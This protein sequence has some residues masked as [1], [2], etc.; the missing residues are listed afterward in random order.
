MSRI[1]TRD[2]G[3]GSWVSQDKLMGPRPNH[4]PHHLIPT[5]TNRYNMLR[6]CTVTHQSIRDTQINS[7]PSIAQ[8]HLSHKN[9]LASLTNPILPPVTS[10]PLAESASV[11]PGYHPLP[12]TKHDGVD[13]GSGRTP[14][15]KLRGPVD[16]PS[17]ADASSGASQIIQDHPSPLTLL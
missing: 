12:L 16:N 13:I 11:N 5:S 10:H 17:K 3:K 14:S 4:Q 8:H 9:I 15:N 2:V 1:H 6:D 7:Q